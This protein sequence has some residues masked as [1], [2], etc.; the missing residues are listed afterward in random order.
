MK[1]SLNAGEIHVLVHGPQNERSI[2]DSLTGALFE[3]L[4]LPMHGE[5]KGKA[6]WTTPGRWGDQLS[7]A[8]CKQW[9]CLPGAR[10][11]Y[12]RQASDQ[13]QLASSA[14]SLS[15]PLGILYVHR[16]GQRDARPMD[17]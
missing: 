4:I 12:A 14:S 8:K 13:E 3:S 17:G 6:T 11:A 10:Q 5:A 16:V 7:T 15:R 2:F 1:E 9:R